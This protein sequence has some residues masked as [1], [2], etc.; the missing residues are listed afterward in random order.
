MN[1]NWG[2]GQ[3]FLWEETNENCSKDLFGLRGWPGGWKMTVTITCWK[4]RT[5][6][7]VVPKPVASRV[8]CKCGAIILIPAAKQVAQQP[9]PVAASN[10]Q[11]PP[12][13]SVA[14]PIPVP[15]PSQP[16]SA[17]GELP[18]ACSVCHNPQPGMEI[19]NFNGDF[20]CKSCSAAYGWGDISYRLPTITFIAQLHLPLT[21]VIYRC[22][23]CNIDLESS[24]KEAGSQDCCPACKLT[25]NIP[26]RYESYRQQELKRQKQEHQEHKAAEQQELKR[27]KQ[28]HQEQKEAERRERSERERQQAKKQE[29]TFSF[30]PA[31]EETQKGSNVVAMLVA[32]L[33]AGFVFALFAVV[34]L[35]IADRSCS[36]MNS[37]SQRIEA[38]ARACVSLPQSQW[39][40]LQAWDSTYCLY[41][42][43]DSLRSINAGEKVTAPPDQDWAETWEKVVNPMHLPVERS[44]SDDEAKCLHEGFLKAQARRN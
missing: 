28:E 35:S 34:V 12:V 23:K 3:L 16:A 44:Y 15:A 21:K 36:P 2:G 29:S 17:V 14:A 18:S 1:D 10:R 24:L 40:V 20:V 31:G 5:I 41:S 25:Y 42:I 39:E 19:L 30:T 33:F 26:G 13:P 4:C 7:Q 11:P 22:P 32:K 6:R 43:N 38:I 9:P 27:Q 37:R 8:E